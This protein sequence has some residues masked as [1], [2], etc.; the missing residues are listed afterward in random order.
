MELKTLL[1]GLALSVGI[2]AVKSGAGISYLLRRERG[3]KRLVSSLACLISC[4]LMFW[5][6]GS[7]PVNSD[8]LGHM[9]KVMPGSAADL[10]DLLL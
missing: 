5:G 9:D 8:L 3:A 1:L 7:L 6:H 2:F 4:L 10:S